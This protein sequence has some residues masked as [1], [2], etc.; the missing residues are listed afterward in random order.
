MK[1]YLSGKITGDD[2]Y[3]WKFMDAQTALELNGHVVLNPALLPTGLDEDDYMRIALAMLDSADMMVCLPDWR[4]SK[5]AMVEHDLC[6]RIGKPVEA[7]ANVC[8]RI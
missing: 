3:R 8:K 1:V 7:I 6:Q 5:G 2:E 4:E